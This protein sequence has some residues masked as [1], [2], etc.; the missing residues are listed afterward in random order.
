MGATQ[1]FR[2]TVKLAF[3]RLSVDFS[4]V[5]K[6]FYPCDFIYN[7][8]S[9]GLMA[10]IIARKRKDGSVAYRAQ[11]RLKENGKQIYSETETFNSRKDAKWTN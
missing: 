4:R 5:S 1:N 8:W 3:M 9:T 7:F 2:D 6:L 10:S 11:I